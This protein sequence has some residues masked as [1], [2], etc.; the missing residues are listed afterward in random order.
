MLKLKFIVI[1]SRLRNVRLFFLSF[2]IWEFCIRTKKINKQTQQPNNMWIYGDI[3][4]SIYVC[5][6]NFKF[7]EMKKKVFQLET[8]MA[9]DLGEEINGYRSISLNSSTNFRRNVY[10]FTNMRNAHICS[11]RWLRLGNVA[12]YVQ[13]EFHTIHLPVTQ[14]ARS[15]AS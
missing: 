7:D 8:I 11:M 3:I 4:D 14:R 10:Q 13:F 2:P 12:W 15:Q 1:T 6:E 5:W 9:L